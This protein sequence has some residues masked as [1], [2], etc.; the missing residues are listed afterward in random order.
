MCVHSEWEAKF[1]NGTIAYRELKMFHGFM[2]PNHKSI[3]TKR[4]DWRK[5]PTK[6]SNFWKVLKSVRS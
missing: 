5:I 1:G 6:D 2:T 3:K 4:R